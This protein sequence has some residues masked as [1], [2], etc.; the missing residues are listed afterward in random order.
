MQETKTGKFTEDEYFELDEAAPQGVRLEYLE[1]VIYLNG[2]VFEPS[3]GWD[4][5][6]DLAGAAPEHSQVKHNVELA[7]GNQ[8][9]DRDCIV[10]SSDQRTEVATK[11]GYVYPDVVVSCDPEYARVTLKNPE[12]MVEILSPSTAKHDLTRKRD[13]YMSR[14]STREFW[15]IYLKEIRVIQNVRTD[16]GWSSIHYTD[17]EHSIRSDHFDLDIAMREVYRRVF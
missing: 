1:G 4:A 11:S 13:A 2:H 10:F 9:R 15:F 3:I 12:L 17:L 5:A 14:E 6:L 16:D 7:I 8:L